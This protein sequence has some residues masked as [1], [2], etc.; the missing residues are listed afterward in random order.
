MT[1]SLR[2][3]AHSE[4]GRIRKNN[5]DAGYASPTMLLVADGMGG[6]AAGDLASAVASTEA[7]RSDVHDE[8]RAADGEELLS[9]IA[10]M[11]ARSNTKLTDLIESNLE[12]DGMGTTFCGALFNGT[13]FG[14][15]HIGDS[16][17]YLLREGT[18]SQLTHDHSWVQSLIDEGKITPE[19]AATHPHRSLILKV[20]N[21]QV[22]FEPD[23]MVHEA[24]LGD[25]LMFCSDG[26]SGLVDDDVIEEVLRGQDLDD[27]VATLARFANDNGGHDN[28]TIVL[29]EVVEADPEL[30]AT[31]ALLVG[32][33]V[34]VEIPRTGGPAALPTGHGY[35]TT[36][37]DVQVEHDAEE[38]AR[39]AP[40]EDKPRWPG[41][42]AT[43]L[44]IALVVAGGWWATSSYVSSRYFVSAD[45]GQVA[46]FNGVPGNVLGVE[47]HNLVERTDIPVD[48]LPRFFRGEV[49]ASIT[50]GSVEAAERTVGT[51]RE[52][53]DNCVAIREERRQERENPP[54]SPSPEPQE[55]ASPGPAD[56]S[57][58]PVEEG[59]GLPGDP[60]QTTS[61]G[62]PITAHVP[63][64]LAPHTP[65]PL[66]TPT[67]GEELAT[68]E[69][70]PGEEADLEDC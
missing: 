14:L 57:P 42:I 17:G 27:A 62:S 22:H 64:L 41:I 20:L 40:T 55:S 19:Q 16:R 39:Y 10:G 26:L 11:I 53:A 13:E 6:A 60:L 18:L 43:F 63:P 34:E 3:T 25:R 46:V 51:L 44:A 30:D 59:P 56:E 35:P 50:V 5:Q 21:G 37:S 28:I 15:A 24:Q 8:V 12:L 36:P 1:F 67:L 48:N 23:L 61:P 45:D 38:A 66:E 52:L 70:A 2:F 33:A 32:S 68:L 7:A 69:P 58:E 29:G 4:V 54:A 47:L 9:R 49:E 65:E 31:P